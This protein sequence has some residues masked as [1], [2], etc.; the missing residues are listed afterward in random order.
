M[1]E[2]IVQSCSTP[3]IS[4]DLLTGTTASFSWTAP[5]VETFEYALVS[6][7]D[8]EPQPWPDTGSTITDNFIEL[9]GLTQGQTYD[10]ILRSVCGDETTDWFSFTFTPP[11]A[12]STA[13]DPIIIESIPYSTNDDTIN[14]GDDYT[15]GATGCEG[16]GS[17]L[18]GDDVVYLYTPG[19]D[20]SIN[21]KFTP[22]GTWN[23]IYVYES[24]ED[25]GVNL[26]LIH[27]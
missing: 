3:S 23:G 17:Y 12:G 14:Y 10:F 22:Q 27:I 4:L 7:L 2:G 11:P 20:A 19:S 26:S 15:N 1:F 16:S 5:D 24:A 8:G 25:I 9:S 6:W 18:G 21:V 13:D